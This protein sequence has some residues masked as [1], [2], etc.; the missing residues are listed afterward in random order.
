MTDFSV[1]ST[2]LS[3][4]VAVLEFERKPTNYFSAELIAALVDSLESLA[5]NGSTRVVILRSTGKH[6]CAGADFSTVDE[7]GNRVL[8]DVE[9]LYGQA[10]RLFAQPLP[11]VAQLQG[12]VIGG[13]LG[14]A[15][16]ADF[17]VATGE[18]RLSANFA[19]LSLHPGF[20]LSVSLPRVIGV[21]KAS[22][23][24][25]TGRSILGAEALQAGL[26]DYLAGEGEL[27]AAA[28]RLAGEI[29]EAGPLAVR[30]IRQ[31]VRAG[32]AE[33]VRAATQQEM[34]EQRRLFATAD[35][36]EGLKAA[37]ERRTPNFTGS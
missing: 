17:R 8:I 12:A 37:T 6:F 5:V 27:S 3:E 29:A 20:G 30:S 19:R 36:T 7:Q 11:I 18:T 1:A 15:M 24:L 31:T 14:L 10:V 16:A 28:E 23:F 26:V 4:H 32:L 9:S 21:Q 35:F 25:Y 22:E 13:G 33:Q 34:A 2:T